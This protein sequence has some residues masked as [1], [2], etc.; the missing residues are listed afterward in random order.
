MSHA[1]FVGVLV[2][3]LRHL[4]SIMINK[5]GA[6]IEELDVQIIQ[7]NEDWLDAEESLYEERS[8]FADLVQNRMSEQ[9]DW[10]EV[11][12]LRSSQLLA[13]ADIIKILNDDAALVK[14]ILK[15]ERQLHADAGQIYPH[16][17]PA[18]CLP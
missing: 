12:K 18:S 11:R 6:A 3:L 2:E 7:V 9:N 10:A 1:V 5:I 13:F 14:Q 4:A 16:A 8:F 17:H 15:L